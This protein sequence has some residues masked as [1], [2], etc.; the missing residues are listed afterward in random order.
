MWVSNPEVLLIQHLGV[1]WLDM[2][3]SKLL[4]Q[5]FGANVAAGGNGSNGSALGGIVR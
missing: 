3:V 1:G 5:E 2:T 4:K